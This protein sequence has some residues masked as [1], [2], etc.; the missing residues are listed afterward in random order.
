MAG[1]RK[2]WDE[3]VEK[4]NG[5]GYKRGKGGFIKCLIE[6]H[7]FLGKKKESKGGDNR[8]HDELD[9]M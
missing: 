9:L 6:K 7:P 1:K 4:I 8:V 2:I 3:K 5:L